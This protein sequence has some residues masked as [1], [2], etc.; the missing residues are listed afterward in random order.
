M[1]VARPN[2]SARQGLLPCSLALLWHVDSLSTA[3]ARPGPPANRFRPTST[4]RVDSPST[5]GCR[6]P[7]INRRRHHR[8]AKPLGAPTAALAADTPWSE[9][10]GG[11][12]HA[13]SFPSGGMAL[14]APPR[15]RCP[16]PSARPSTPP[17]R[18]T[19]RRAGG[20]PP[21]SCRPRRP[22]RREACGCRATR[23]REGCSLF[24]HPNPSTPF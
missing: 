14:A 17:A 24:R 22:R 16:S 19:P 1:C 3:P 5:S 9:L 7:Q 13:P 20:A 21:T 15:R 12:T 18:T 6:A 10:D 2:A 8:L 23:A 4:A 11:P